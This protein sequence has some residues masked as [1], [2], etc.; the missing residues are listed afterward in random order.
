MANGNPWDN[1]NIL[2]SNNSGAN[3]A[4]GIQQVGRAF[5]QGVQG[6]YEQKQKREKEEATVDW[7]N[8][9]EQ[10]VNQLFPQ[11]A[12]VKDPAERK[13]VIKAGIKGAG[14]EN[15][16]QVKNFT[17][18]QK[19]QQ[20]ELAIQRELAS[21]KSRDVDN[22]RLKIEAANAAAQREM[23]ARQRAFTQ[24]DSPEK[25]MGTYIEAGGGDTSLIREM[26]GQV[27]AA[28]K[29]PAKSTFASGPEISA[30][31]QYQRSSLED[32]WKPIAE[33]KNDAKA[34]TAAELQQINA[35]QQSERDLGTLE[36]AFAD[37][38]DPNFGGPVAGRV[39][40]LDPTNVNIQRI[41]SLV[42]AATPNLA[43]GVFREV[44][45]LTDEDIT[46]YRALLPNRN[47]TATQRTQKLKDLRS[48]LVSS[49]RETLGTLKAAGRDVDGIEERLLGARDSAPNKAAS[50]GIR[51]I[52]SQAE[53]DALPAGARF[54][55]KGRFGI[56]R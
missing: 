37:I 46:R 17:D 56:K 31:G 39:L 13:K 38:K 54:S 49:T 15:L 44:G 36:Q 2:L 42:T 28:K 19:R 7:L 32:D 50:E 30:D 25:M 24:A 27:A 5:G 9:N 20:D 45:V 1:S 43:R 14:L 29:P 23:A 26:M 22:E 16:V 35:L 51:E 47:D 6:Y 8:Q 41:D 33:K 55:Y 4:Q 3:W 52:T 21:V 34:L 12:Q 10:A 18:Q 40:G 11:L 53:F 48:R